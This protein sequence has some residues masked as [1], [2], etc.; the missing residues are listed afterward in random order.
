[1]ICICRRTNAWLS[2]FRIGPSEWGVG[3]ASELAEGT[4]LLCSM[5][6]SVHFIDAFSNQLTFYVCVVDKNR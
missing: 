6:I 3:V 2:E 4:K 1:M 5:Q